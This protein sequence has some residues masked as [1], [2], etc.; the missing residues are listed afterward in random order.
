MKEK[1]YISALFAF[2][3]SIASE[4]LLLVGSLV[5]LFGQFYEQALAVAKPIKLMRP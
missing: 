1:M 3:R 2:V 5:S 4:F